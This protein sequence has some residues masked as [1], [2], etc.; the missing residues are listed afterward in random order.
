[1]PDSHWSLLIPE[2]QHDCNSVCVKETLGSSFHTS[3]TMTVTHLFPQHSEE[4]QAKKI[5]VKAEFG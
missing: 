1:M 5:I 2:T 4:T 3:Y